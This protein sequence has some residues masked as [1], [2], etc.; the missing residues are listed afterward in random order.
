MMEDVIHQKLINYIKNARHVVVAFSGGVDSA[1]L[2]YLV[3]KELGDNMMAITVKTP[4]TPAWEIE[5]A[6]QFANEY[7]IHHKVIHLPIPS[8]IMQN[9]PDRCYL[10]KS[11]VFKKILNSAKEHGICTVFDGSNKDDLSDYRPG[12]RALKELNV[13]S[14]MLQLGISKTEIRDLSRKLL[15]KTWDK[16]SCACLLSRIPYHTKITIAELDRISQAEQI[17]RELK[18]YGSRV[19]SQGDIARIEVPIE[20]L[21]DIVSPG[22]RIQLVQKIRKLGYIHVVVDLEGYQSGS[23]NKTLNIEKHHE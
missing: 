3:H 21:A 2:T 17:L 1:L 23:L 7:G 4:Y 13:E 9:P 16:P 8:N 15:L 14:P 6:L 20:R 5:D 11:E 22:L 19:R 10:C 12:I 18:I